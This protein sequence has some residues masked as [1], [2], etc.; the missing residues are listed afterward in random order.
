MSFNS[1][2]LMVHLND[3]GP[4][5]R[6]QILDFI[7]ANVQPERSEGI[8]RKRV[9][10]ADRYTA[11]YLREVGCGEIFRDVI[12]GLT[13]RSKITLQI[14]EDGVGRYAA[15]IKPSDDVKSHLK[16]NSGHL[17]RRAELKKRAKEAMRDPLAADLAA[18]SAQHTDNKLIAVAAE[19]QRQALVTRDQGGP[20][21]FFR[22]EGMKDAIMVALNAIA[23]GGR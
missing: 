6:D 4:Q 17:M 15:T 16:D 13:T 11:D 22:A 7:R 18:L 2:D 8:G 3:H 23:A 10:N 1:S 5:T 21:A 14:G 9:R 12:H 20:E 19:I